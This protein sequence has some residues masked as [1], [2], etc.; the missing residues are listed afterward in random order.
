MRTAERSSDVVLGLVTELAAM[1]AL[2]RRRRLVAM[3]W[4]GA[5]DK[6]QADLN[7]KL[8]RTARRVETFARHVVLE[9]GP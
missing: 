3:R 8:V 6:D 5:L 7:A 2:R 1:R 9:L 4:A